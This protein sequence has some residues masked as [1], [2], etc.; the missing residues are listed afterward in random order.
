MRTKQPSVL[1]VIPARFASTRFSGKPLV[2]IKG[3]TMIQR[4]CEQVNQVES[5]S[6]I[7][8]A[9]DDSRIKTHVEQVG[10]EAM[11]TSE[12]HTSGTERCAEVVEHLP[13]KYDIVINVQGDEPFIAPALIQQVIDGFHDNIQIVTAVK[14]IDSWETL[15]NPNVVKAVFTENKKALYFSRQPI[16]FQRGVVESEWLQKLSYYKHIGIYGFRNAELL[17][18]VKLPVAPMEDAE[19]LE[20][21]RWLFNG[22]EIKIVITEYESIG[23]DTAD[24]LNKVLHV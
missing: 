15:H 22:N 3:K 16:P 20:Q 10:Y 21:L 4:V 6:R 18:I 9:T 2:D 11:M 19:K 17:K 24:D 7:I 14:K 12:D 5:V 1:V 13:E 23:I 8:V